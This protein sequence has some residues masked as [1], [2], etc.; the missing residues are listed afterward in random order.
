MLAAAPDR[1]SVLGLFALVLQSASAQQ[2]VDVSDA[3]KQR[4]VDVL[5]AAVGVAANPAA[6]RQDTPAEAIELAL[7]LRGHE[8]LL[9]RL[10]A[11]GLWENLEPALAKDL[12]ESL[13]R[14]AA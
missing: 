7:R 13:Q 4:V 6:I 3:L 2:P 10:V 9:Q 8:D 1:T 11:V 14:I 5:N 12:L